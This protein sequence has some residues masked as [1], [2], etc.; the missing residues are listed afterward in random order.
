MA[1]LDSWNAQS[2]GLMNGP[3]AT[4]YSQMNRGVT[5]LFYVDWVTD[6]SAVEQGGAVKSREVEF[7]KIL[8]AGDQW[9]QS[10]QPVTDELRERF[11]K[12]Y[13]RFKA[14]KQ[15][16]EAI[17]G[18]PLS[19]WPAIGKGKLLEFEMLNVF[20]VENLAEISDAN[21]S[22]IIDGRTWRE[23]AKA[24]LVG[25][26]D[27]AALMKYAEENERLREDVADLRRQLGDLSARLTPDEKKRTR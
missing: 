9:N 3:Q 17:V 1:E 27:A 14:G 12:E 19:A 13:E 4:D 16:R 8:V 20:T 22:K 5:P 15:R 25:H 2:P 26:K 10:V 18:T 21:L 24:W 6:Y 23:K 7:V 11:A